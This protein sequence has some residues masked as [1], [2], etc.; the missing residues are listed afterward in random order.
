MIARGRGLVV[1]ELGA[2][3]DFRKDEILESDPKE[4]GVGDLEVVKVLE[5]L[6]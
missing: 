1:D 4:L 5:S 3:V 2:G 6:R